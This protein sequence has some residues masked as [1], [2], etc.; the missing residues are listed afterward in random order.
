MQIIDRF[1][2]KENLRRNTGNMGVDVWVSGGNLTHI[3][4]ILFYYIDV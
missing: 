1:L 3:W 4:L 2:R